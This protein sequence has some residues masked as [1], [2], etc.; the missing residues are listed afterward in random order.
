L[1]R[2][3]GDAER[4]RFHRDARQSETAN[5]AHAAAT[6]IRGRER[7]RPRSVEQRRVEVGF[8][9][10]GVNVGARKCSGEER[11][12]RVRG[13]TPELVDEQIARRE[14][15]RSRRGGLKIS[16]PIETTVRRIQQHGRSDR[17]H[18]GY[19]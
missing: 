8:G 2:D 9:A 4:T 7:A 14:N 6:V 10:V 13:I 18:L 11:S 16:R 19:F 15:R 17:A 1:K 3:G 5:E 12:A